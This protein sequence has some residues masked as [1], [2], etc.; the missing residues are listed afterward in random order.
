MSQPALPE[1]QLVVLITYGLLRLSLELKVLT[2]LFDC[3]RESVVAATGVPAPV[4]T[5]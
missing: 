2:I 5:E 1:T 4:A 3:I